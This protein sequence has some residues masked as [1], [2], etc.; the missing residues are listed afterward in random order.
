M[1]RIQEERGERR[2]LVAICWSCE[3]IMVM[4][5]YYGYAR[6]LWSC[7][8]IMVMRMYYGHANVFMICLVATPPSL[9]EKCTI[10]TYWESTPRFRKYCR[11]PST[12][13]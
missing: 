7:E 3:C 6:V 2:K 9:N 5:M 12:N 13:V 4:R 11:C 1:T 10:Q 8:C